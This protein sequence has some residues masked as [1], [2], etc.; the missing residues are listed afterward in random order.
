ME[1][2]S[3]GRQFYL[4][5]VGGTHEGQGDPTELENGEDKLGGRP[6]NGSINQSKNV[7]HTLTIKC[8]I[9]KEN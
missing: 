5:A 2:L 3:P 8:N 1:L 7:F 9:F 6:G 4:V